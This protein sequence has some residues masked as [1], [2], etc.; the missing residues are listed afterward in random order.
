MKCQHILWTLALI[1]FIF[2]ALRLL[3]SSCLSH[4]YNFVLFSFSMI[5]KHYML[6]I[7]KEFW[8]LQIRGWG[9]E[10]TRQI[11]S[12]RIIRLVCAPSCVKVENVTQASSLSFPFP[13]R[14]YSHFPLRSS[15]TLPLFPT[16][17]PTSVCLP[18]EWNMQGNHSQ[19]YFVIFLWSKPSTWHKNHKDS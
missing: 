12:F 6:Y 15:H 10:T 8:I 13:P 3:H 16:S 9:K 1:C 4:T 5:W 14:D 2:L 17:Y 19:W 18:L 11:F 7:S